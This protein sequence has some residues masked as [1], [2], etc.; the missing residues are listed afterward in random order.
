MADRA[1]NRTSTAEATSAQEELID[2]LRPVSELMVRSSNMVVFTGAGI[3]TE[4]GIP[5]YRGS[6]GVWKTNR[7]PTINDV[8]S[9]RQSREQRWQ[10]QR[11]RYP[12][13]QAQEPN[14]GHRAIARLEETGRVTVIVTQNID[15]LHQKAGSA[16]ERV[17]ELHGSTHRVRCTQCGRRYDAQEILTRVQRGESDPRCEVCGGVLRPS[18]VLF[19]EPLPEATLQRAA[20]ASADAD[21]MLVV[22][23]SLVV[24]PASQLP[25]VARKRGA[26]LVIVNRE[27]TPLD[28]IA[29]AV[30]RGESGPVLE[31]LVQLVV[32]A[33]ARQERDPKSA[34]SGC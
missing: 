30:V 32:N 1:D 25:V 13:M 12:K 15:G 17:L 7:I 16:E 26:E 24:K 8:K 23:S 28:D 22:G 33:D 29:T 10:H 31:S 9:D 18:T 5:D 21:L 19:G 27:A 34:S 2:Q 6:D 4:S 3:S 14:A 11:D 20:Q